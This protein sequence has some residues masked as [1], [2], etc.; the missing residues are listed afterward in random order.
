MA[1][2]APAAGV[3]VSRVTVSAAALLTTG[4]GTSVQKMPAVLTI[5][6]PL[7]TPA[8][9][10]ALKETACAVAPLFSVPSDQVRVLVAV[11]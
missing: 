10:T 11:L 7:T 4:V 1:P 2:F 8:L 3:M 9:I 5:F 6:V